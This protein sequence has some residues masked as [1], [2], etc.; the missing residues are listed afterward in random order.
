M[1]YRPPPREERN[2]SRCRAGIPIPGSAT[3]CRAKRTSS[4]RA[5]GAVHATVEL[6]LDGFEAFRNVAPRCLDLLGAAAWEFRSRMKEALRTDL[7]EGADAEAIA[8]AELSAS[9]G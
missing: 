2:D 6:F 9:P 7:D 8:E 5:G 3:T 1:Y 4:L